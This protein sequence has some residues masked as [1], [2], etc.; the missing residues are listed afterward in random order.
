MRERPAAGGRG[1]FRVLGPVR[2][3]GSEASLPPSFPRPDGTGVPETWLSSGINRS[4]YENG[5]RRSKVMDVLA[6]VL[7]DELIRRRNVRLERAD[8]L[9]G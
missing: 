6:I 1:D 2:G 7:R 9:I 3:P 8:S 5:V 4:A